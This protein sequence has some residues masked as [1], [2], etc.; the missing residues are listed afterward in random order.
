MSHDLIGTSVV[1]NTAFLSITTMSQPRL[2]SPPPDA[3]LIGPFEDR[4]ACARLKM[5]VLMAHLHTGLR[6]L[7]DGDREESI[8][9]WADHLEDELVSTVNLFPYSHILT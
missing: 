8:P 6:T 7:M 3:R 2:V 4:E 1:G 5:H 9:H